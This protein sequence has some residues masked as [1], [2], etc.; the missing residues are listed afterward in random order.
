MKYMELNER[1]RQ[2]CKF[3]VKNVVIYAFLGVNFQ[4]FENVLV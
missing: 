3:K 2:K 1:K 4:N